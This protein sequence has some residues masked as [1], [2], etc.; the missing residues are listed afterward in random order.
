MP[1]VGRSSPATARSSVDLPQPDGPEHGDDAAV[2]HLEGGV[3]DGGDAVV[4]DVEVVEGQHG[5]QAP[6]AGTRSRSTAS[7]TT[8][9]AAASTTEA[10]S[11]AP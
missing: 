11:A 6:R 8:A 9:V 3:D 5:Y 2:G 4:V 10:A 1:A 7:I